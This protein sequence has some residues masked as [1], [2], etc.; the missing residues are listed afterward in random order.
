MVRLNRIYTK[1]GDDGTTGLGDGSRV[2]K[3]HPRVAAYGSVD[4]LS[5]V[6]GLGLAQG[7]AEPFADW[8]LVVQNDLFDL[9]S[10]LCVPGEGG[11]TKRLGA[12]YTERIEEWIDEVNGDL[13]PLESF[14]LPGGTT[15]AAWLHLARTTCRRAERDL[16]SLMATEGKSVNG[17]T[18][19]YL[20]R[21]SDLLFVL[22]R[23]LNK[24]AGGDVLWQPGRSGGE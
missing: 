23:A 21:L 9:G 10:D 20:N 22:A 17:E 13:D 8:L 2:P 12:T 15:A 4:E 6:I 16:H 5:S 7:V 19:R 18:L 1:T 14:I 24:G 11:E 3:H